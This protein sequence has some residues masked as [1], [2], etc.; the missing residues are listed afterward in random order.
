MVD[1]FG[2]TTWEEVVVRVQLFAKEHPEEKWIQGR[3]WDQNK[4]PGKM[5]PTNDKL[6]EAFS[7]TPVILTRVD[8]HAAIVNQKTLDLAGLT[9]A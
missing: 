3:G 7:G 1:L 4:W 6:N 2:A 5:Y 8:G 9:L